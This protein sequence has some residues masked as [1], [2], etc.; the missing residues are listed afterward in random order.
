MT[1]RD[2]RHRFG[3]SK[4]GSDGIKRGHIRCPD[5]VGAVRLRRGYGGAPMWIAQL[6]GIVALAK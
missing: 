6:I 1:L 3:L 4:W 2:F 5:G